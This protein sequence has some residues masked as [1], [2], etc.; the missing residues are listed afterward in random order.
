MDLSQKF[1]RIVARAEELRDSLSHGATG[2]AFTRASK[3]LSELEPVVARI[4]ELRATEAEAAGAELLLADPELHDMAEQELRSL[5]E[6][7]PLLSREIQLALLPRDE[8]DERSAI[9]EI[10]PAAIRR[11]GLWRDRAW[12]AEGRHRRDHRPQRLR[13][14]EIRIR[15]ASGAARSGHR[16]PGQ[17][18]YQHRHRRGAAGSRGGGRTGQ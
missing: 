16:N 4:E 10:R 18:P 15:G 12:R 13:T 2:D 5:R 11:S 3:E 17:D 1:D 8:A 9:L 14:A 7:L 6:R